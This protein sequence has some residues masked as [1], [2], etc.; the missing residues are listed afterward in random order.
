MAEKKVGLQGIQI[1]QQDGGYHVVTIQ[2]QTL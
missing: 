1:V 2:N